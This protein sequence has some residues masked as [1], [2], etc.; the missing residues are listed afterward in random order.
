MVKRQLFSCWE[1][2]FR[3]HFLEIR[4]NITLR[5]HP[6]YLLD[7]V[8]VLCWYWY[9]Y[10]HGFCGWRWHLYWHWYW[11]CVGINSIS[12]HLAAPRIIRWHPAVSG[13]IWQ[14]LGA[15]GS[16]WQHLGSSGIICSIWDHL[17]SIG[18]HLAASGFLHKA[19]RPAEPINS[20]NA[21]IFMK[22]STNIRFLIQTTAFILF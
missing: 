3:C 11:H 21:S 5:Q 4:L 16:I 9:W 6:K 7:L 13:S 20:E 2:F 1:C 8:L 15:S 19:I 18:Q 12:Q 22:R 17:D 10:W 14:Q